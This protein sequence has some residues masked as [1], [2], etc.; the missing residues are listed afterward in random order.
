MYKLGINSLFIITCPNET[1]FVKT[2][3]IE[4]SKFLLSKPNPLVVFP[5]G[6]ISIVNT[7]YPS[8]A[9]KAHKFILV[10]VFPTPPF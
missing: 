4:T 6:S 7:L 1:L 9:R 3:Y 8:I 5:C 10:V 2:S